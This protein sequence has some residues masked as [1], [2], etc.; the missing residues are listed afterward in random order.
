MYSMSQAQDLAMQVAGKPVHTRIE[1]SSCGPKA[2]RYLAT[3]DGG[4]DE[5]PSKRQIAAVLAAL[6]DHTVIQHLIGPEVKELGV[7]RNEDMNDQ[8]KLASGI[9]RFFL[10]VADK[11]AAESSAEEKAH[12]YR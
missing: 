4:Y 7:V 12:G 11:L 9:G 6:S 2:K 10:A 5:S 8:Y 3:D 1:G